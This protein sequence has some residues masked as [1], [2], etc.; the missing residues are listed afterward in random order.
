M[1]GDGGKLYFIK[2]Y[3]I[4]FMKKPPLYFPNSVDQSLQT[5][6]SKEMTTTVKDLMKMKRC[7]WTIP[8]PR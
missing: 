1:E 3:R 8:Y 5:P 2:R 6:E 4:P 7:Y